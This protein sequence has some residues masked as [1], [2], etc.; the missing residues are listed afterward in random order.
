[1]PAKTCKQYRKAGAAA[2]RGKA[3]GKEMVKKTPKA[4]RKRC[5][6]K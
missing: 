6:K 3:W 4:M 1:M 5:S 2:G